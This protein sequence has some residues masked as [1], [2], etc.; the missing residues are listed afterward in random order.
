M[1]LSIAMVAAIALVIIHLIRLVSTGIRHRT[2][3]R[4]IES[5]P[6][7]AERLLEQMPDGNSHGGGDDRLGLILVAVGIA[8]LGA[9]MTA[10]A[11]GGWTDYGVGAALFPLL[12]GAALWIRHAIVERA[13]RREAGQ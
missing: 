5:N 7:S 12:V 4:V 6:D 11:T 3:R 10:G 2:L 1:I 13:R 8:M 9:S